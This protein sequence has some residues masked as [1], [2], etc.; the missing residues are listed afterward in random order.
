VH[1]A[2]TVGSVLLRYEIRLVC[3]YGTDWEGWNEEI[4]TADCCGPGFATSCPVRTRKHTHT[5]HTQ[6]PNT[7]THT[8]DQVL[9]TPTRLSK[10]KKENSPKPPASL[11]TKPSL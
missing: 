10:H 9:S 11:T 7:H 3:C 2:R 5:P 4:H 6:N 8:H 1:A